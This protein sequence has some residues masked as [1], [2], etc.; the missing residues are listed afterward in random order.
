M[1]N[2]LAQGVAFLDAQRKAHMASEV[3]YRRG[4]EDLAIAAT[5]GVTRFE[6]EDES[7]FRSQVTARDYLVTAADMVLGGQAAEPAVGDTIRETI[8]SQVF[9]HEVLPFGLEP[10]WRWSDPH[11]TTFRIHTKHTS[12]EAAP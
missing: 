2:L 11:R 8:G 12:T 3:V 9:V 1:S 5:V 4:A 7:G 10:A 6:V